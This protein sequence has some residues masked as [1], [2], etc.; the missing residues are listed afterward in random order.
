MEWIQLAQNRDQWQAVVNEYRRT[1]SG[2]GTTELVSLL[3]MPYKWE[4]HDLCVCMCVCVCARTHVCVCVWEGNSW[5]SGAQRWNL[6]Y[7][8]INNIKVTKIH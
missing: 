7:I 2:S 6:T 1:R 3:H 5:R 4:S 8:P